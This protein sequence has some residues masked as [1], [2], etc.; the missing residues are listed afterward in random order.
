MRYMKFKL[1]VKKYF[2]SGL[3][4]IIPITVTVYILKIII[5]F[6]DTLYPVVKSYLPF[7][8]PG[9]GILITF[10]LIVL[11]GVVTT[12]ILG[13]RLVGVGENM[14]ARIPLVKVIYNAIKQI[15]EAIFSAEHKS[16]S[17][18]VLIEYP[19]KGIFTMAFVTGVAT[20]EAQAKT[21]KKVLNVFVPTTPNPTSGFYLMVPDDEVK[22]LDM[23][24]EEAF[25]SIVSGGMA[26]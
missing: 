3:L 18:V 4:V 14:I 6:T 7:Y 25:K 20:G 5:G 24:P 10:L 22:V 16:F 2:I 17:R 19:R 11:A 15:S 8:I 9:F 1:S 23:K 21:D 13:K 26:S 12:N